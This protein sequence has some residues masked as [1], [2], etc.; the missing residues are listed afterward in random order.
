MVCTR[1][2]TPCPPILRE[3]ELVQPLARSIASILKHP[4]I[5]GGAGEPGG[6]SPACCSGA[7]PRLGLLAF[8]ERAHEGSRLFVALDE[9]CGALRQE[10]LRTQVHAREVVSRGP[11]EELQVCVLRVEAEHL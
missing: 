6:A 11:G 2:H 10:G 3:Q 9:V 8:G 4:A 1:L 7:P 5:G